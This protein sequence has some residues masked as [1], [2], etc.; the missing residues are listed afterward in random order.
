M[1]ETKEWWQSKTIWGI[2][3]A[4]LSILFKSLGIETPELPANA[5][6][7]Q[8][9]AYYEAIKAAKGSWESITTT[10]LSAFG[11]LWALY[12]RVTAKKEIAS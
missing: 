9:A 5:D 4:F 10:V 12:G 6:A 11:F 2:L 8:I 7:D 1:T 3:I